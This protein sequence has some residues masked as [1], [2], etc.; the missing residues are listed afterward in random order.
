MY[1]FRSKRVAEEL[2]SFAIDQRG[3]K[4]TQKNN[5]R[6][7]EGENTKIVRVGES[8]GDWD[9]NTGVTAGLT[10][11]DDH[12]T[13]GFASNEYYG[14]YLLDYFEGY[15]LL[16]SREDQSLNNPGINS[17]EHLK[18]SLLIKSEFGA[19]SPSGFETSG[20]LDDRA[21]IT[22]Y[23]CSVVPMNVGQIVQVHNIGGQWFYNGGH[24][25]M[26]SVSGS[27]VG[28]DQWGTVKIYYYA[29]DANVYNFDSTT[30][31]AQMTATVPVFNPW[32]DEVPSGSKCVLGEVSGRLTII[33][34]EC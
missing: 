6:A 18:T 17:N 20:S 3:Y 4:P 29:S 22:V 32:S 8:S 7:L 12:T 16:F 30:S 28:S 10:V 31:F 2:R 13:T 15:E 5:K 23:N 21:T 27:S 25:I 33:G 11:G 9:S 1:G 14:K 24:Q 34:W 26:G 19:T